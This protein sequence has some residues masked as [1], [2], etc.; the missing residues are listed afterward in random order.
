MAYLA[1]C[2]EHFQRFDNQL[3]RVL[4]CDF[5]CVYDKVIKCG[6]GYIGIE[7]V[8]DVVSLGRVCL[9]DGGG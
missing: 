2:L 7:V 5:T 8:P 9:L 1:L 4:V 3:G 6:I